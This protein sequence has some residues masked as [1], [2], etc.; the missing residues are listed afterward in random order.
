MNSAKRGFNPKKHTIYTPINEE[1]YVDKDP[2]VCKSSWEVHFCKWCDSNPNILKWSSEAIQIPYYDPIQKKNRRYYPD[3]SISVR[4]ADGRITNYI[5][6]LKPKSQT[7]KPINKG[8]SN[9]TYLY[10]FYTYQTNIAKWRAAIEF[11]R[12]HGFVFKLLTEYDLFKDGKV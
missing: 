7:D 3:F 9:K 4:N 1:K 8:K 6:E 10:E 11:C 5:I 2:I 12:K